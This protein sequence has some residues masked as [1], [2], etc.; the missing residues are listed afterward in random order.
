MAESKPLSEQL[1]EC[2]QWCAERAEKEYLAV[3]TK[4]LRILP[5][6]HAELAKPFPGQEPRAD[7]WLLRS[8]V[9]GF[10]SWLLLSLGFV[11]GVGA[12]CVSAFPLVQK[13]AHPFL[14]ATLLTVPACL[15]MIYLPFRMILQSHEVVFGDDVLVVRR[16][17]F[18]YLAGEWRLPLD[19]E[20]R[21]G[22]AYRGVQ[23]SRGPKSVGTSGQ[24]SIVVGSGAA[25]VA[26]GTHLDHNERARLAILIDAFYNGIEK[27]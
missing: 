19:G 26:F 14:Y 25:E 12:I 2:E 3:A 22:L 8:D 15:L 1:V 24:L 4:G 7:G 17:A 5:E 21:V 13:T 18:G 9:I 16:R 6:H 20:V 27:V 11:A 23:V 10:G